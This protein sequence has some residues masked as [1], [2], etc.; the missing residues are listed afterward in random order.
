MSK[1][2]ICTKRTIYYKKTKSGT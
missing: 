1:Q 2:K